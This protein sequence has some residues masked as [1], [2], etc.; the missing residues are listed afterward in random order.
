MLLIVAV[1]KPVVLVLMGVSGSGKSTV[2]G[3]LA[4]R[5]GWPF[6]EG[7]TLH[8]GSNIEKMSAGIP[9][10]DADR[11]LWLES[12][13][14]WVE[15]RLDGA[16]SG[17]ITC[18]AL[19][20]RY[21]DVINRRGSGVLFV[22]LTG[23]SKTIGDRLAARVGHFMPSNLIDSQLADLED[24]QPDEPHIRVDTGRPPR[25]IATSIL[26]ELELEELRADDR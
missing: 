14:E 12:V 19:K 21:R 3:I 2:A 15:R 16:E 23:T 4:D 26:R 17:L 22:F 6:E 20:R 9:L 24:P 13:T 1:A 10:A 7:D 25:A 8:P 11:E 18:S 5:L